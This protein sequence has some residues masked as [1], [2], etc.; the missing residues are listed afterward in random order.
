MLFDKIIGKKFKFI[1]LTLEFKCI[2]IFK[3][4]QISES[5]QFSTYELN[6]FN[7][8]PIYTIQN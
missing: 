1:Y 4:V 5:S 3:Y 8:E 6:R 2:I 7:G